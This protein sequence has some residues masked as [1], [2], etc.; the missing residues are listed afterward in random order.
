MH[1][2][3]NISERNKIDTQSRAD[4][5]IR[6]KRLISNPKNSKNPKKTHW[7]GFFLKKPG[8][9]PTLIGSGWPIRKQLSLLVLSSSGLLIWCCSQLFILFLIPL[10][11]GHCSG[12]TRYCIPVVYHP[13]TLYSIPL[14]L[15]P[16]SSPA[17]P[18]LPT[19]T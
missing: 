10:T 7:A 16:T 11:V 1:S 18:L 8:F 15:V 6:R 3:K 14:S 13:H 19:G 4:A 5:Y 2:I 12:V 9:F 17:P